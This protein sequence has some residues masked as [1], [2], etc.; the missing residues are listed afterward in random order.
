[1]VYGIRGRGRINRFEG[2]VLL[3]CF[4]GYMTWLG[5]TGMS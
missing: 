5:M 2:G 3:V 1:M 4:A